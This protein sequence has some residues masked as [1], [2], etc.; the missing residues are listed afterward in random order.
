MCRI[1]MRVIR[2]ASPKTGDF[3]IMHNN[4]VW[5]TY[6]YSNVYV[7]RSNGNVMK[8]KGLWCVLCKV[9]GM[10]FIPSILG[11]RPWNNEK[12]DYVIHMQGMDYVDLCSVFNIWY[13]I[14]QKLHV[15]LLEKKKSYPGKYFYSYNAMN[16]LG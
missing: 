2:K 12:V 10:R 8:D 1:L 16:I 15:Q 7:K 5:M 3:D 6:V 13:F 9:C 14:K 4:G 11:V